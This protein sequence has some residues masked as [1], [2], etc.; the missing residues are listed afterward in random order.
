VN[1]RAP[2]VR[3]AVPVASPL[4]PGVA[5]AAPAGTATSAIAEATTAMPRPAEREHFFIRKLLLDKAPRTDPSI[6]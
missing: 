3:D 5:N 6:G 2:P 4:V 1:E